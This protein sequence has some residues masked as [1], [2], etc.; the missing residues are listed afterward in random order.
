MEIAKQ[1][2]GAYNFLRTWTMNYWN[3]RY[4]WMKFELLR[5]LMYLKYIFFK[6]SRLNAKDGNTPANK[7]DLFKNYFL[8]KLLLTSVLSVLESFLTLSGKPDWLKPFPVNVLEFQPACLFT[9]GHKFNKDNLKGSRL[10]MFFKI[11]VFKHF[12]N[13]RK[14]S[15]VEGFVS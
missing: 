8:E 2:T 7:T 13:F 11:A 15:I 5:F 10:E 3:N 4:K 9:K 12:S 14:P 1:T 6:Q